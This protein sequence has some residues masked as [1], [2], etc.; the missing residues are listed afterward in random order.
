MHYLPAIACAGPGFCL[1][2]WLAAAL[3]LAGD[4]RARAGDEPQ[5]V[6]VG[7]QGTIGCGPDAKRVERL[8]ISKPGV[9]ENYLVDGKWGDSTLVKINADNVTLRRCEIRHG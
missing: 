7:V 6:K 1:A 3:S 9:Y 5:G 8:V 4:M 2:M